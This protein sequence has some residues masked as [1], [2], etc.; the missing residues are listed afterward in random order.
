MVRLYLARFAQYYPDIDRWYVEKVLP[1]VVDGTRS[2]LTERTSKG[3]ILGVAIT[4]NGARSKL[5]HFSVA[6]EA[7]GSGVGETLLRRAV[8]AMTSGGARD[9]HL[10]IGEEAASQYKGFFTRY[11]F[12]E[13]GHAGSRY[14]RGVD[15]LVWRVNPETLLHRLG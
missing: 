14:R 10:T 2:I 5:C 9:I 1:G 4:K 15:E 3:E 11:G 13:K 8:E 6:E 12:E 7:R